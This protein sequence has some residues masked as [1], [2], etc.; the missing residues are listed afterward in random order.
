MAQKGK[1][2]NSTVR[3]MQLTWE[4]K[5]ILFDLGDAIF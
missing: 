1:N 2:K 4:R 5:V 3:E